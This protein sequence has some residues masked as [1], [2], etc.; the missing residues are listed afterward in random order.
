MWLY[1][2]NSKLALRNVIISL[3]FPQD[4]QYLVGYHIQID[5]LSEY[6]GDA[7]IITIEKV[8]ARILLEITVFDNP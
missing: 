4:Y 3:I 1:R 8:R 6:C 5:S 2:L 7:R